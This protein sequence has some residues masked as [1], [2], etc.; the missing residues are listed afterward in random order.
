MHKPL[1]ELRCGPEMDPLETL[2][3]IAVVLRDVELLF[4]KAYYNIYIY[5]FHI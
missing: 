5:T 4:I 2:D 3:Y 1:L